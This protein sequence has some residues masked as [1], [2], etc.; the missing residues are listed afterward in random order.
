MDKVQVK[1]VNKS[2]NP[3]PA[4]ETVGSAGLDIRADLNKEL[5]NC[6][7][8]IAYI[9]YSNCTAVIPTGIYVGIPVGYEIQVRPR[10]GL[11]ARSNITILNSPG[12]VDSDYIG[13][14]KV[15][16][17]NA[18]GRPFR[19]NNGDRIAQLVLKESPQLEW[20]QVD[21][22]GNTVR[23]EGGFGHTGKS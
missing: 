2:K 14:I 1:I 10:S 9:I 18:A 3:L 22:L 20:K 15:I 19:I 12:T 16:L 11:S 17:H 8:G 4:Y 7:D 23:G 13:E 5:S 6:E 21:R